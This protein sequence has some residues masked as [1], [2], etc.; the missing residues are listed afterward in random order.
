MHE[1]TLPAQKMSSRE[2][3]ELTGKRHDHVLRDIEKMLSDLG[4]TSPQI[5][6]DLE[7]SYGRPQRVAF[8]PK[9]E[10]LILVSGYSVTMR[11][12][13]IDR[14]QELESVHQAMNLVI[15]RSLPEALRLAA[16]EAEKRAEA[17]AKLA[18]AAPKAE[19]LDRIAKADGSVCITNAAKD[20]QIQPKRLFSW[21][22]EHHWIYR[23]QGGK[24]WLAYQ[25]R[26]QSG[27]LEHK[28]TTVERGDGS[29]KVVE[30]VLVTP[31]G[32]T[33]LS[34]HLCEAV[35]A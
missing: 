5:W 35:T 21:L 27:H 10:T 18:I 28:V 25:E 26:I 4:E 11:A 2:I 14:W 20:L 22:Q 13:I 12:R 7:D 30:Q 29:E 31:K 33:L 1:L 15:P 8:L 9:R 17:E 16:D 32:L 3:A 23:R 6:G 34:R 24:G 19:A